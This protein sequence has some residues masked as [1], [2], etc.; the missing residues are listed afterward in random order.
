METWEALGPGLTSKLK[1]GVTD[2]TLDF[3]PMLAVSDKNL[4][5]AHTEA[6]LGTLAQGIT[7]TCLNLSKF[8]V[9]TKNNRKEEWGDE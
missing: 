8:S 4:Q 6:P 3:G 5:S 9:T 1:L 7:L 2:L